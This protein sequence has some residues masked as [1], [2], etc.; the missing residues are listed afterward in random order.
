MNLIENE[1]NSLRFAVK[2]TQDTEPSETTEKV[3]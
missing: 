3:C 2:N 1:Q